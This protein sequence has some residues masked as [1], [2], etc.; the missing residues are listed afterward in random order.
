MKIRSLRGQP[1]T[2]KLSVLFAATL[3]VVACGSGGDDPAPPPA[4]VTTLTGVVASGAAVPG[5]TVTISDASATTANVSAT[6]GAD[7]S[8]SADVTALTAP[9]LVTATGTL[10]GEAV[11]LAAVVPAAAVTGAA[12]NTANVTSLT[13]AIA[14]LI[15][16]AGN[17]G[18]LTDPAA[19]TAAAT[20]AGVTNASQLVVNTLRT[21]PVTNAALGDGFDP[22]RTAFSANGSGVDGC[23][24]RLKSRLA[25]RA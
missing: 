14:A 15:A 3:A 21:D 23:S 10:N 1:P 2:A 12:S 22:L 24:I 5:A 4:P 19:L 9:L 25:P 13:N 6:S 20:E 16:P 18:A 11:S 8:Y 17:I 7:G